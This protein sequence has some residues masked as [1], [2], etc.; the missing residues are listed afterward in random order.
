L[1]TRLSSTKNDFLLYLVQSSF[2]EIAASLG[3]VFKKL[4][5]AFSEALCVHF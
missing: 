3:E 5:V 1:N 2:D 4:D